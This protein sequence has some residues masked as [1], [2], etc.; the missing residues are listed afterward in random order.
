MNL[1]EIARMTEDQARDYFESLR[2]PN[3]PICPHCGS[4][5]CTRLQGKK[6]RAG[7]IQ[8]NQCRGNSRSK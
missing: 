2:W 7:T 6:H 1:L 3:G 4:Q 8:C 5:K